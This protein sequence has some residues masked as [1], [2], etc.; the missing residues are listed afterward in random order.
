MIGTSAMLKLNDGSSE[1]SV[2]TNTQF[3]RRKYGCI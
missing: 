1:V 2:D 3:P